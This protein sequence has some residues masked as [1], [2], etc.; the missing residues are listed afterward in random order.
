VNRKIACI[1][2]LVILT[3]LLSPAFGGGFATNGS[4]ALASGSTGTPAKIDVKAENRLDSLVVDINGERKKVD[5]GGSLD[6][7]FGDLVTIVEA[8]LLDKS[9]KVDVVDLVGFMGVNSKAPSDDRGWVIDTGRHLNKKRSVAG[10]G[11]QYKIQVSGQGG[12][13]GEVMLHVLEPELISIELDV[14]GSVRRIQSGD[15]LRLSAK[16]MVR[17]VEIRTNVRGN[18]NVK[19]D[20]IAKNGNKELRFSRGGRVFARIPIEW[21][22][23]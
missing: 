11:K 6:V 12:L 3:A 7:V 14:N 8:T 18:E 16:D 21:Q 2:L 17:V 15:V 9:A 23:P 19:Y 10:D 5:A 4:E 20:K 1:K 22:M 13:S